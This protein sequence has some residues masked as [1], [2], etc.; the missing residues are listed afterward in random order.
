MLITDG[1]VD[2]YDAIFEKYNWPD[3]KVN[4]TMHIHEMTG[5]NVDQDL[6]SHR[7][8]VMDGSILSGIAL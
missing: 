4:L 3:R 1:A 2:T 6:H 7:Y 5:S 8:F